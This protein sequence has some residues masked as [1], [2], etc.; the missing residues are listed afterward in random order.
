MSKF[1]RTLCACLLLLCGGLAVQKAFPEAR[2]IQTV[3]AEVFKP[4]SGAH[5]S[6][7]AAPGANTD[8]LTSDITW[9]RAWGTTLYVVVQ[10]ETSSIVNVMINDGTNEIDSGLNSNTALV[11]GARYEFKLRG[12]KEGYGIQIQSETDTVWDTITFGFVEDK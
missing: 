3:E 8:A 9:K 5:Q 1:E 4:I 2:V 11:A 12:I 10:V 6:A 7:T